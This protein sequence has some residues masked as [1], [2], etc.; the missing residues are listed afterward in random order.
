[1]AITTDYG[2]YGP[3]LEFRQREEVFSPPD[4]LWNLLSLLFYGNR[5]SFLGG[6]TAGT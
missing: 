4:C 3:G 2:L 1:M 6:K 5:N